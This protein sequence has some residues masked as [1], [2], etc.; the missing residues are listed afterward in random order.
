MK[1]TVIITSGIP[2]S[3][4]STLARAFFDRGAL[5]FS[6]DDYTGLYVHGELQPELIGA[7]HQWCLRSFTRALL[8]G[9]RRLVVD[10][11]NTTVAELAP[12]A[13]LAQAYGAELH[14]ITI[15]CDVETG[16]E[17]NSHGASR[18]VVE[19]LAAQLEA[20]ALPPW[21][22]Q[23]TLT[24]DELSEMMDVASRPVTFV[25]TRNDQ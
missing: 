7:A 18:E 16:V 11:T 23:R 19:T 10:N 1:Q 20:R 9:E 6:A 3:G 2:G 14:I 8:D 21:W 12:Y 13:A 25:L 4:K 5:V 22:P 17:R 24:Q 15:E